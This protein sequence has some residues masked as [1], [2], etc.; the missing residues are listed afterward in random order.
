M[1]INLN[2]NNQLNCNPSD[3]LFANTVSNL[4][5][6]S[7][8]YKKKIISID[9]IDTDMVNSLGNDCQAILLTKFN[10]S[11]NDLLDETEY[12]NVFIGQF[13]GQFIDVMML[14][15]ELCQI[16]WHLDTYPTLEL[17]DNGVRQKD[18]EYFY[19]NLSLLKNKLRLLENHIK[20]TESV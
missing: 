12:P 15:Q 3:S 11:G 6:L 5:E 10:N 8:S 4:L 13:S 2:K 18:K 9:S 17:I 7:E 16:S 20:K 19:K 14:L 1:E